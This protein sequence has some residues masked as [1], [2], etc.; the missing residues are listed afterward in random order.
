MAAPK[1][2]LIHGFDNIETAAMLVACLRK[3]QCWDMSSIQDELERCESEDLFD[4]G[5]R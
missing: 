4:D 5:L 1:P 2:V 3:L